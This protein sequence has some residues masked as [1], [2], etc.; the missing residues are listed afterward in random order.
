[1]AATRSACDSAA[2]T[3][4]PRTGRPRPAVWIRI[5][6]SDGRAE[7]GPSEVL[8]LEQ[9]R[10]ITLLRKRIGE[11]VTEVQVG[12]VIS[13]GKAAMRLLARRVLGR[14]S[15]ARSPLRLPQ[16]TG[17][18]RP[19]A[20]GASRLSMTI[21]ISRKLAAEMQACGVCCIARRN[22]GAS[23]SMKKTAA[24]ADASTTIIGE[25]RARR[26]R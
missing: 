25:D 7:V 23:T 16:G 15:L 11:A 9:E 1:M 18:G 17:R 4:R 13:L 3:M 14:R 21:A 8:A 26:S 20:P 5:A 6:R 24:S 12:W 2:P 19:S 10:Q 22:L